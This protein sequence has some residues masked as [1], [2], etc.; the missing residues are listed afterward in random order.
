M[1]TEAPRFMADAMLGKLTQW[2]RILGYDVAYERVIGDHQLIER[3]RAENRRV[4]TRDR[5]LLR[6]RWSPPVTLIL[7][8]DD[9][10]PMQLGQIVRE[11]KLSTGNRLLTRCVHC[12]QPIAPVSRGAV[13]N[14]IPDYVYQT[15]TRFSCCP[16]CHRIY[17]AGTH[18][19]R[20]QK[21]LRLIFETDQPSHG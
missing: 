17:W 7:I 1:K 21:Q 15:Q 14:K 3:A 13:F 12:N 18:L 11:M 19:E 20:I 4:L 16:Q 9:H 8:R 2:L 6:R 5:H 10:L